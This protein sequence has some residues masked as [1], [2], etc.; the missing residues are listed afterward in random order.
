MRVLRADDFS[1]WREQA[2]ALLA[3]NITPLDVSWAE[4][5]QPLLFGDA[6]LPPPLN[7]QF[8]VPASF[9]K[10]AEVVACHRDVRRWDLLYQLLFRLHSGEKN[11]LHIA[12]DPLIN[13]LELMQKS[14]RRDAHKAKAFVRFRLVHEENA[15]EHYIAWHQPDHRILPLVAPFFARRFSS[16]VWTILSPDQSVYWN[17]DSLQWGP[18]VRAEEAPEADQLEEL[19]RDYYRATFNP[20][21]IKIAMMKR[22]MPVRYWKNL[23]ET[24]IIH[25]M[26]AE[27]PERVQAMVKHTQAM[28]ITAATFLPPEQDIEQ[29]RAAIHGCQ[30]CELYQHAHQP[31]FGEGPT[32][33]RIMLVGEQPGNEE[34]Q[35]GHPFVGPAGQLLDEALH[36]IGLNRE[37][38]YITNAVKHFRFLYR[39]SFR[40]HQ[41]P[42][43]YHVQACKPWLTAEIAAVKPQL[44]VCLGNTAARTLISPN[45]V[46]KDGRGKPL[47]GSPT[48]FA[49]YHPSA[50][51]RA[52]HDARDAMHHAFTEDLRTAVRVLEML[53]A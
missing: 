31:V 6:P 17:G 43:R 48:L 33:A 45:F 16:M 19:W 26:L 44:I 51:L 1:Q 42:S 29:L 49:T 5:E 9:M 53:A 23:P 18:G 36:A 39:D 10:I 35:Q 46:M 50:I 20:A 47:G 3:S 11:L 13:A 40:Q 34:D 15:G 22:E 37:E 8:H 25:S 30:G 24:N 2:R 32:D 4:A 12:T 27:A 7:F 38:L 41:T 28:E 52:P 21:R 14:V